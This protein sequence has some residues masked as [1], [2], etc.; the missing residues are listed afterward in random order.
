[1]TDSNA[2]D[3]TLSYQNIESPNVETQN[4]DDPECRKHCSDKGVHDKAFYTLIHLHFDEP[5][6]SID[7]TVVLPL[8][9]RLSTL[10]ASDSRNKLKLSGQKPSKINEKSTRDYPRT[11][12]DFPSSCEPSR[13]VKLLQVS[14]KTWIIPPLSLT[15]N[16]LLKP[17]TA[18]IFIPD[19]KNSTEI[20]LYV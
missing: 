15:S 6:W 16:Y 2:R 19:N 4:E 11:L 10:E 3:L 7:S 12:T 14:P 20:I 9:G 8:V 13:G 1:V 17:S 18:S 5:L